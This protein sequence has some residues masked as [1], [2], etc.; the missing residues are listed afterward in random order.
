MKTW[1]DFGIELPPGHGVEVDTTCPQCSESRKKKR[2]RCLSV[3][4]DKG[5]W[6]CHHCGWDGTLKEG[7]RVKSNPNQ[8]RRTEYRKPTYKHTD[9]PEKVVLWFKARG[10]SEKTLARNKIGYGTVY[11]P[12]VE[13]RTTAIQFPYFNGAEIVNVK[14]RDGQKNFRMETGAERVLYGLNDISETTIVVEGELDK[15]SMDE[16]GLTNSV[17]VPD[18]APAPNTKDYAGKFTYMES[19][20]D[21]LSA[22]KTFIIAVDD[23]EPGR[24]LEDEL[25]RRLG[26]ERCKRVKWPEGCK[27]ANEVLARHGTEVLTDCVKDAEPYP[28]T[29]VFE[30]IDI[31]S[32]VDLLYENGLERG[33]KT[34]W[35][36]VD[37]F[38]TVRPGELTIVT[39]IP[40]SGKSNWLDALV[41]NLAKSH[42]W[43]FGLFSPENQPLE[44]HA[45][46]LIEKWST[47]PFDDGPTPRMDR[48]TL[49]LGKE[50]AQQHF[51][52]ILPDE[53]TDWTAENVLEK[54]K[55]LVFRRGIRGLVI[56]PWNE[57]E[58]V[59]PEG[60]TETEYTSRVLK[61]VRQ[62]ARRHGVH[63]WFVAH[64]TKLTR[65]KDDTYPVPTPYDIS[66]S[67][68]WRNKADNC[69]TIWRDFDDPRNRVIQIHVQ[70]IRFRQIGRIGYTSLVYNPVIGTYHELDK[71]H[72]EI[73]KV[74]EYDDIPY[75]GNPL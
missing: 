16:A 3:N 71:A 36:S 12:Q 48:A 44:D 39:G 8:W 18:G 35:P 41:V 40:N 51:A 15:L 57:L 33:H 2:A 38:Y 17:S 70:K 31:S 63:I 23:D 55:A 53:D 73:P 21:K 9:L 72:A 24:K 50:W 22:V 61:H 28:I 52:W 66:G 68:H 32:K 45:A 42:G 62:F 7:E 54:A 46:R 11:M 69:L 13:D 30:V 5:V 56:D 29:G 65:R 4:T 34:G 19:A 6:I 49:E 27:D 60:M 67:A 64:P 10:I 43:S 14:Y 58:H 1:L 37:K 20:E 74:P 47:Q 59:R 25:A 26:R 75:T